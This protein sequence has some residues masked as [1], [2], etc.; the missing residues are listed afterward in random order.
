MIQSLSNKEFKFREELDLTMCWHGSLKPNK[1]LLNLN[2]I[3]TSQSQLINSR[4]NLLMCDP[5][6]FILS[7]SEIYYDLHHNIIETSFDGLE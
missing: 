7:D 1:I 3:R 5:I 2:L 6:D 4:L